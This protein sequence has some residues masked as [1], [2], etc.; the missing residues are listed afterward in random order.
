MAASYICV[1]SEMVTVLIYIVI[2]PMRLADVT[3][4]AAS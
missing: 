1:S 2:F 3:M 4:I